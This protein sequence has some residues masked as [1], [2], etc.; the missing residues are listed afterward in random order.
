MK[1]CDEFIKFNYIR[2]HQ[3]YMHEY[4][5]AYMLFPWENHTKSNQ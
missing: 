5:N 3:I 1:I 2:G 4:V